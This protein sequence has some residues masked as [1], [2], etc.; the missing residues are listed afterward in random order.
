MVH[1][2]NDTSTISVDSM[3]TLASQIQEK[4]NVGAWMSSMNGE[5]GVASSF[6]TDVKNMLSTQ[7]IQ[8][9]CSLVT[10]GIIPS[11]KSNV[12]KSSVM[13]F[14]ESDKENPMGRLAQLQGATVGITIPL[15]PE[16]VRQLPASRW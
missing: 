16:P 12:V 15:L 9:H 3:S 8:S 6:A 7:N 10:M 14:V 2:L 11:I 4:M 1:I 13:Q 5:F